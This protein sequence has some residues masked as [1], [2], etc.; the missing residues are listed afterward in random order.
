MP[1]TTSKRRSVRSSR[2]AGQG[3]RAKPH[4]FDSLEQQAFLN[5]WRTYDRLKAVEDALFGRYDLTAQ[6]YNALRLL[7]A[8]YPAALQTLTLAGRLI[9]RSPDITRLLDKL[10]ERG[11]IERHR[12]TGNRRVVQVAITKTGVSLLEKLAIELRDCH[13]KQLGHLKEK[14]LQTLIAL[15]RQARGP[16]EEP[17]ELS[18]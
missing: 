11:L 12:P 4:G 14:K 7:R 16:H 9:S 8:E 17:S 10:D 2:A 3:T 1:T 6:Q 5:L 15:L 13:E 18:I